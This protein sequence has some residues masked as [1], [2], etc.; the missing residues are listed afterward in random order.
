MGKRKRPKG[1]AANRENRREQTGSSSSKKKW[2]TKARKKKLF[3]EYKIHAEL[4]TRTESVQC[5]V[6]RLMAAR[7]SC[8]KAKAATHWVWASLAASQNHK[9]GTV[10]NEARLWLQSRILWKTLRPHWNRLGI[11]RMMFSRRIF[12]L[13]F[14]FGAFFPVS[15]FVICTRIKLFCS[16]LS[17][18]CCLHFAISSMLH[19]YFFVECNCE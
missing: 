15:A 16:S 19:C 12:L 4:N 7:V 8:R 5:A 9:K 13:C 6:H 17:L 2:K 10:A 3:N 1:I 14:S 11:M 18:S